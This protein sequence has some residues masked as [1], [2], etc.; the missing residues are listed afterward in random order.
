MS[1]KL[2]NTGGIDKIISNCDCFA[3]TVLFGTGQ[4]I[5]F[6]FALDKTPGNEIIRNQIREQFQK[7]KNNE[8]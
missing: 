4:S 8:T 7:L 5:P 2:L 6:N 3:A 1:Q